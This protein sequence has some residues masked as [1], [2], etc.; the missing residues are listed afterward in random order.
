MKRFSLVV[1]PLLAGL[2]SSTLHA[3]T[4]EPV[5]IKTKPK[6]GQ[7]EEVV[8]TARKREENIQETPVAITALSGDAL[9]ELGITT[10]ADL[11]KTV[12]S[13]QINDSTSAQIYIRGIGQR[14]PM[15]RFDP[16][17]SVYLDGIFIPRA[18]GQLLDTIDIASVQVLRG[19]Q[20]TLFGK[21][22][23]G[24]AL[25]FT[26]Q[27]PGDEVS[28]YIEGA[29]GNYAD[30]RL[31]A[32]IDLPVN[33]SFS[34][35][36]A[37]NYQRRDGFLDDLSTPRNQS[38]DRQ[39]LTLQTRWLINDDWSMDSFGFFGRVRERYPSYHCKITSEDALFVNGLGLLWPGDTDPSNPSAYRENCEANNRDA[40]PDLV[41]NQGPSQQQNKA[42]DTIMLG[43]T[44]DWEINDITSAKFIFGVRDA[45]KIGPQSAADE[46]GPQPFLRGLTLGDNAQDSYTFEMQL[47]GSFGEG[48]VDY[49]AGFFFQDE[50]K[51]ER[52][53]TSSPLT[54][55]ELATLG[56]LLAGQSGVDLGALE[57]L[58]GS[59][60]SVPGGTVPLILSA[61][62]LSLVQDFDISGQTYAL[63]SQAT[64]HITENIEMTVGG[65]YTEEYRTSDLISRNAD[66]GAV[67][68]TISSADPR[69]V[70][71]YEDMGV[72]AYLGPWADD[73]IALANDILT[74]AYPDIIGAPL[75]EASYDDKDSVFRQFTPMV[76]AAWVMP[77]EWFNDSLFDS[78]MIYATWSNGFKSGFHE[79]AGVD[80]LVEIQPEELENQELGIK[81]DA[82]DRTLRI[83][84]ALYSMTFKNM[85]LI[86]VNVDS[87]NGLIITSQNA[88]ESIIEGGEV[89]MTWLPSENWMV[90]FSYSNN[91]YKYEEF[92]DNDLYS[93][94]AKA[95]FVPVDRSQ[96][97]FAVSPKQTAAFGV[98]YTALTPLGVFIPRIDV[99]YKDKA[100]M[101]LDPVSW[102]VAQTNPDVIYAPA[103]TLV[104]ARLT[105][106][107]PDS[108]LNIAGYI[109]NLTDERYD[110]G[111]VATSDSLG[112]Y[113]QVLGDPRTFGIE[114]RQEF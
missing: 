106:V 15:A 82:L 36:L 69:F 68:S 66:L 63:F 71:A 90:N 86:T 100:Y 102:E 2:L 18:D 30:Q 91:N 88:G 111:A 23:T 19:P 43:A 59:L 11:S 108:G 64:W 3:Q 26:L 75:G 95:Q 107:N 7:I 110:I 53:L 46:G 5:A 38:R 77:E 17:V 32:G 9:R 34:T 74:S 33:E 27:K 35:R 25:V 103:Y 70:P 14:A 112:T 89:E 8:V 51:S 83:N 12:P 58:I 52:F 73:P 105:W 6:G 24:G 67:L 37:V 101:G 31:R 29:L 47:N 99:S 13:L 10:T 80:G 81:L 42:S 1:T 114:L 49:T 62:P 16:S 92:M 22:N 85:Q 39:S 21:N 44:F 41:T 72:M 97:D 56:V 94:A 78:T 40:L 45:V 20:G 54:G 28:G 96:E 65:R 4:V 104:D 57:S 87:A 98:Q 76:S 61:A 109:K 93:L 79:P 60:G 50:Y 48:A 55:A 113:S 84:L